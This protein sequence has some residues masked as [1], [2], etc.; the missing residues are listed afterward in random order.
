[1][2]KP[3]KWNTTPIQTYLPNLG[4][5]NIRPSLSGAGKPGAHP[6]QPC[7]LAAHRTIGRKLVSQEAISLSASRLRICIEERLGWPLEGFH[8]LPRAPIQIA[9][10]LKGCYEMH[11][12]MWNSVGLEINRLQAKAASWEWTPPTRSPWA[13]SSWYLFLLNIE[14]GQTVHAVGVRSK[15]RIH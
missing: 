11:F 15:L 2:S 6:T 12:L 7:R 14:W 9:A 13:D 3:G 5:N 4:L 8:L 10:L 1:M